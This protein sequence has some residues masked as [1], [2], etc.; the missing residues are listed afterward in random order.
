D[1]P[2]LIKNI[3]LTTSDT[4]AI[5]PDDVC[6]TLTV[7]DVKIADANGDGKVSITDAVAI[8]GHILGESMEGFAAAAADVNR[9]GKISITDAVAVVDMILDGSAS[10]K[11]RDTKAWLDP[12]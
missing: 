9:D 8:V 7:S 1:Y 3:E 4:Q 5:N 11:T 2:V 10:A 6:A 12:Q